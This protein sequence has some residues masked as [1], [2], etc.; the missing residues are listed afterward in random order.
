LFSPLTDPYY[1]FGQLFSDLASENAELLASLADA[2]KTYPH[3]WVKASLVGETNAAL[4]RTLDL[5]VG[6]A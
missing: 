6:G 3:P 1:I 2:L 4:H 5:T